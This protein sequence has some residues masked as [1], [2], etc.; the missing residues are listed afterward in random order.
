MDYVST[1][2]HKKDLLVQSTGVILVILF[3][4]LELLFLTPVF[5]INDDWTVYSVL[6]GAY[7]GK[8][9]AHVLFILYPFA[10]ILEKLY[11][12]TNQIQ[13]YGLFLHGSYMLGFL[14]VYRRITRFIVK[15]GYS[16]Y[17]SLLF[18][19]IFLAVNL[20]MITMIQY[21]VVAGVC[22][23]AAVFLFLTADK[24]ND[25]KGFLK[26]NIFTFILAMLSIGIRKNVFFLLMPI[27]GMSL[28][29]KWIWE[30]KGFIWQDIKPYL[31]FVLTILMCIGG[32]LGIHQIAYS[33][34]EWKAYDTANYYREKAMDFYGWVSYDENA[35]WFQSI[36]LSDSQFQIM[37]E[38][39]CFYNGTIPIEDFLKE[40]TRITK[41][42][43]EEKHSLFHRM[44]TSLQITIESLLDNTFY[45]INLIICVFIVLLALYLLYR[46]CLR[47]FAIWGCIF[48]GRMFSWVAVLLN[49]RF[50]NRIPQLLFITDILILGGI[51]IIVAEKYEA[52]DKKWMQ[53]IGILFLLVTLC[54]TY[55]GYKHTKRS[56]E[57]YLQNEADWNE[58]K[59]YCASNS[60]NVYLWT[61][62]SGTL[63]YFCDRVYDGS[64]SDFQ[65]YLLV[66]SLYSLS[67]NFRSK[68]GIVS[69]REIAKEL[70]ERDNLY[71][72]YLS[73]C[74]VE[75]SGLVKWGIENI[76]HFQCEIV[77]S[78][79]TRNLTY[80]VY[81]IGNSSKW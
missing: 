1:H 74:D 16:V 26:E 12:L 7:T 20:E 50:P 25:V 5:G 69:Q 18:G 57:P 24:S 71:W 78:F 42:Q 34:D 14:C 65:N 6:S 36:E 64:T 40:N 45:P 76:S 38:I 31:C 32:I 37:Q 44:I 13:W 33:S 72:V 49:G 54:A 41:A 27:A 43:Y 11:T 30:Q 52:L 73:D 47:G 59:E 23:G 66:S 10:W 55:Q 61:G 62:G 46:R 81:R 4:L 51:F 75:G 21:T 3:Y 35:E 77:D 22:G 48:F 19:V 17:Y 53:R 79:Q 58:L 28:I 63:R 9:D 29:A 39:P 2:S 80:N 15:K 67:P 70:F 60:E 56:L 68:M 8:P